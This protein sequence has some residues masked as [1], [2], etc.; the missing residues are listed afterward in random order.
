MIP[1]GSCVLIAA[2]GGGDSTALLHL[3]RSVGRDYDL[4]LTA[5][6]LDHGLRSASADEASRLKLATERFGI[7]CVVGRARGLSGGQAG[8]RAVRYRFLEETARSVAADR[9]ALGHQRDDQ[10]ETVLHRLLRGTGVRGLGGIPARRDAYVRP[11]LQFS[12]EELR[13]YLTAAGVA[14]VRDPSNLDTAYARPRIRNDLIPRLREAADRDLLDGVVSLGRDAVRV[15]GGLDA[16]ASTGLARLREIDVDSSAVPARGRSV[17]AGAQIARSGAVGYDR[18][19]LARILRILARDRGFELS[20]GGTRL[21]V[22]FMRRGRS[23]G[24]VDL[25]DGLRL[26]REYDTLRLEGPGHEFGAGD[27]SGSEPPADAAAGLIIGST[28]AGRGSLCIGGREYRV[29]WGSTARAGGRTEWPG[30]SARL[31]LDTARFPLRLRGPL[32]GDRI[33]TRAGTK[34]L[35]KLLNERRVPRSGRHA[36][37]VLADADGEVVWVAGHTI[38]VVAPASGS[39]EREEFAIGVDARR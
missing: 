27:P 16:R 8:Y 37:P 22:Q 24:A 10:V 11:L 20:R 4:A 19:E 9:I 26:V 2:S 35:K 36:V 12:R 15:D 29:E 5:A 7:P 3:M 34:K 28:R 6:H 18:A 14:W 31:P 30:W 1:R 33:R 21:G 23:G 38:A 17:D 25:A 32:P 39:T 13:A